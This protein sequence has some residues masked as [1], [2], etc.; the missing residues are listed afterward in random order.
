MVSISDK[1]VTTRTA[2]A[3]GMVRF[4]SASTADAIR[5]AAVQKGDVIAVSR[6]AAIQAVK[7]TPSLIPLTHP[8]SITKVNV[9]I[10]LQAQ[11]VLVRTT[12]QSEGKTGVE[13]EALAGV[14]GGLLTM[15]DMC[16]G[17]DKKMMIGNVHV[18]HKTGGRSDAQW[19]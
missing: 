11:H 5:K 1:P 9:D 13:M 16:K 18:E 15:Y 10:E 17:I 3:S 6:V 8:I 4:S 12:V 14:M 19:I 2:T 7:S